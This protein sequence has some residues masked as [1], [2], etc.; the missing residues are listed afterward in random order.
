[1]AK[2]EKYG[3]Y[4]IIGSLIAAA[5]TVFAIKKLFSKKPVK[6]GKKKK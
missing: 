1:M 4:Q 2:D 6:K 5:A 3:I